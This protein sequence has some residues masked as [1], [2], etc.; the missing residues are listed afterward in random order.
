[1]LVPLVGAFEPLG[2]DA[3]RGYELALSEHEE[4]A[5]ERPIEAFVESTDGSP[6]SVIAKARALIDRGASILIG[7]LAGIEGIAIREFA[8]GVPDVTFINGA[9]AAQDATLRAPA[10]N[11]FRFNPDS[12]QWIAGLGRYAYEE[13]GVRTI[14]SIAED[15]SLPYTQLMGFVLDYCALGGEVLVRHWVSTGVSDVERIARAVAGTETDALFLAL[16]PRAAESFLAAYGEAGGQ[17]AIVAGATTLSGSLLRAS[18]LRPLLTG[19]ISALPISEGDDNDVW[20]EFAERYRER[21]PDAG[22]APSLFALSY[23]VNTKAVLLALDE[24]DGALGD[25]HELLRDALAK[26][27]FDT[28]FGGPV[29]LDEYR[30]AI[31]STFIVEV[32]EAPDGSLTQ[33]TVRTVSEVGQTLGLARDAFLAL[34]PPSRAN[35]QCLERALPEAAAPPAPSETEVAAVTPDD[36]PEPEAEEEAEAPPSPADT[37]RDKLQQT[38]KKDTAMTETGPGIV[39]CLS[40]RDAPAAITWLKE[41][42]GFTEN[43][44]VPGPD[45]TI[46]HAQLSL[47]NGMVMVGSERDD[48]LALRIPCDFGGITQSIYVVVDDTDAHY[49]QAVAA[50]AEIVR[51][52]EDT[53]YGSRDYSARDP[54]GHLWNFGT[55]RPSTEE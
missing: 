12:M 38:L 3:L 36:L 13:K 32:V 41:A 23:Y 22:P 15:Y 54:E 52:L 27:Q 30:Q 53:P 8:K 34:G 39:P 37:L 10:E 16:E 28:P 48:A 33:E 26:L 29:E 42:F 45:G 47:G 51:E 46:V 31:T 2:R 11:F 19:A 7:P 4:R 17:A 5:G 25:G 18:R 9:S 1:M 50:G 43:M 35:S 14:V 24:T 6:D 21:F 44:V 40:Y 55:Y 49:A 20:A